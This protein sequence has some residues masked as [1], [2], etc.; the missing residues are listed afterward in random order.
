VN[1]NT[2]IIFDEGEDF[3]LLYSSPGG[4]YPG[5]GWWPYFDNDGVNNN[6][7][8]YSNSYTG[9]SWTSVPYD[10]MIRAG[11]E[12]SGAFLDL[13]TV[14]VSNESQR[15]FVEAGEEMTF[16][17]VVENIGLEDA[18]TYTY[19][20]EVLN[21][22]GTSV[23]T[24]ADVFSD[25]LVGQEVE[26]T[27]AQTWT[28]TQ[29][30]YY[31]CWGTVTHPDDADP[32]NDNDALDI[33]VLGLDDW[34]Y[35]DDGDGT[36]NFSFSMGDEIGI[37]VTP[38]ALTG[39]QS[40]K[41]DSIKVN[42]NTA[43]DCQFK[44]YQADGFGGQPGTL[45]WTSTT[46]TMASGW[47]TIAVGAGADVFEGGAVV[48]VVPQ[49][50]ITIVM[51]DETPT[52]GTNPDMP[53]THW[54]NEGGWGDWNSGDL[55][56]RAYITESTATPPFPI[57]ELSA[58]TIYF[59]NT[60]FGETSTY[61]LTINNAGGQDNLVIS[62]MQLSPTTP[63]D[64]FTIEAVT[65]PLTIPAGGS[66]D[67]ELYFNPVETD[68][69]EFTCNLGILSNN[70]GNPNTFNQFPVYGTGTTVNVLPRNGETPDVY[71]LAQ[72]HPNPFNPTT[73]IGY[74][75]PQAG[76]VELVVFNVLGEE[77]A[78]L[79]DGYMDQGIHFVE[80]SGENLTSGIYFYKITAGDF[81]E[82]K[83]MILMK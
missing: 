55:L 72:N 4:P 61:T 26:L 44:V 20:W 29:D 15:F 65:F 16:K 36:V 60:P 5:L 48:C 24:Y 70:G 25:L 9:P 10:A 75:L 53:T 66:E 62:T 71:T 76:Q 74:S 80:F 43:A 52:A 63:P 17:A 6:R 28:P 51:D 47:N 31:D 78:R 23:W 79:V 46:Q 83:K 11:G 1:L 32:S 7:T 40:I 21:M 57:L 34:Y 54:S 45:M 19:E 3:H 37:S 22:S 30:G 58:D 35:F 39:G 27:A 81:S 14:S 41:V 77:I 42:L 69:E 64:I 33:G 50:D 8:K 67:V 38:E 73:T 56:L 13:A 82:M 68:D 18:T 59:D 12:L 2:P 49:A